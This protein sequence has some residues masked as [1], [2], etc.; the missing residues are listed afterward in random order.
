MRNLWTARP[1]SPSPWK[2]VITTSCRSGLMSL[3]TVSCVK[4]SG[5]ER[6]Y[7]DPPC[8]AAGSWEVRVWVCGD[9]VMEGRCM[10]RNCW[11]SKHNSSM[12]AGAIQR[13][14]VVSCYQRNSRCL[15]S[16]N[17]VW[18]CSARRYNAR[19]RAPRA[20][21]HAHHGATYAACWCNCDDALLLTERVVT[22]VSRQGQERR[23]AARRS[24]SALLCGRP[25]QGGEDLSA[26]ATSQPAPPPHTVQLRRSAPECAQRIRPRRGALP[27]GAQ[28]RPR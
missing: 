24:C 27:S 26:S 10:S 7:A 13:A 20:R 19:I 22:R 6:W 5:L 23:G 8:H 25:Q 1:L 14:M 15:I 11:K 16:R 2:T 12:Q 3:D 18:A 9:N 21:S 17:P 4:S 28:R